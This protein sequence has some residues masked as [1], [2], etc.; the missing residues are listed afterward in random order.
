V[1]YIGKSL[2]DLH[3]YQKIPVIIS[4]RVEYRHKLGSHLPSLT[5][6]PQNM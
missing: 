6:C 2:D 4:E 3:K 1:G 5:R